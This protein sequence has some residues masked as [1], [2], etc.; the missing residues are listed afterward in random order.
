MIRINLLPGAPRKQAKAP[1]A[2]V[3]AGQTAWFVGYAVA[4]VVLVA[5]LWLF[6]SQRSRELREQVA[7][8]R[9]LEDDIEELERQS[10]DLEEVRTAL[11]ESRE[12]ETV[13]TELQRARFGPTRV[14]VE[15][16][17]ILSANGGPTIDPRRLEELRR[18]NPL[19][20]FNPSW[21]FHRLWMTSF[22]EEDR[23]VAI[24]GVGRTND[25]VAEFLRRLTLSDL[26]ENV[27]LT[28][29]EA[30]TDT[31][32]RLELITFE[33]EATVRY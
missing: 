18:D 4:S 27:R 30:E 10:A 20:G 22:E 11:E 25:D 17:H 24:S 16:S 19:A 8:N 23:H 9:Q 28:R 33:L 26:F 5:G 15:V 21:D 6:Y 13:V 2:G 12:L 7:Q 1:S 31:A 3:G 32:T 29:T 14:L